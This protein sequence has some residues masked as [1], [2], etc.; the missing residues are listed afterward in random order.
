MDLRG[1]RKEGLR[2]V[3]RGC[4]PSAV[5]A[6]RREGNGSIV[7]RVTPLRTLCSAA[8]TLLLS[9]F[10]LAAP[11]AARANMAAVQRYPAVVGGPHAARETGLR[12]EREQL[13]LTCSEEQRRPVCAFEARYAVKNPGRAREEV[14]VAFYG[15][16]ARDVT[17]T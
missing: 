1:E 8:C 10:A 13:S 9:S 11:S 17:I 4:G 2:R 5:P 15:I 12:V 16:Q 14:A 6:S 3:S 7:P